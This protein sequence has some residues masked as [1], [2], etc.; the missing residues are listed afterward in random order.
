MTRLQGLID[1]YKLSLQ[2]EKKSIMNKTDKPK[3]WM[4][5]T[6][7]QDSTDMYKL[8][9]QDMIEKKSIMIENG[10]TKGRH[11]RFRGQLLSRR[12][13]RTKY[14]QLSSSHQLWGSRT[15]FVLWV[16]AEGKTWYLLCPI[17]LFLS[18]ASFSIPLKFDMQ[19]NNHKN[20]EYKS[21][22]S[23]LCLILTPRLNVRDV[24]FPDT[25]I[26]SQKL[27]DI[28]ELSTHWGRLK[29]W[30]A[31]GNTHW[32][33]R[34]DPELSTHKWRLKTWPTEG[35]TH[36]EGRNTEQSTVQR[37]KVFMWILTGVRFSLAEI[38]QLL[39]ALYMQI[40][41]VYLSRRTNKGVVTI[42]EGYSTL[43]PPGRTWYQWYP[44]WKSYGKVL[45]HLFLSFFD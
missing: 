9:L 10:K 27:V 16:S 23:H 6:Q 44:V 28:P 41:L 39:L 12:Q 11:V 1:M 45:F 26:V 5:R 19:L 42:Q 25:S 37:P 22:L 7:P 38:E 2:T 17:C 3:D 36:R 29:T 35:H 21:L 15:S 20:K 13:P 24:Y 8:T 4:K 33:G 14:K 18:T 43:Q 32:E 34:K 40:V 30:P 31:E